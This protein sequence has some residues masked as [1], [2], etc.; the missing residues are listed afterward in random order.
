MGFRLRWLSGL[1]A[2]LA[3]AWLLLQIH[4]GWLLVGGFLGFWA[5]VILGAGFGWYGHGRTGCGT[6]YETVEVPE[7]PFWGAFC[8][9]LFAALVTLFAAACVAEY[10]YYA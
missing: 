8:L 3:V 9:G 10:I 2:G 6:Q 5:C 1:S 7:A 4:P